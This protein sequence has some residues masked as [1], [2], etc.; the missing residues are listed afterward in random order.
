[1]TKAT[2]ANSRT[3]SHG[4][5]FFKLT[6]ID[7]AGREDW[8][9][10]KLL[11]KF[12]CDCGND[13]ITRKES[14]AS[15][16]TKSCGC[17]KIEA[18]AKTGHANFEHGLADMRIYRIWRAMIGRC[19]NPKH[20]RFEYY[21]ERGISVCEEWHDVHLFR[22]WALANGYSDDLTIDRHPDKDGNYEPTNCRWATWSEQQFNRRKERWRKRPPRDTT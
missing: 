7:E 3:I 10:R 8:G 16:N 18:C 15:G 4:Q 19:E 1:M 6:A 17:L 12:R 20:S 5:K 21:G 11:W 14:V 9:R 22:G 13:I 2:S